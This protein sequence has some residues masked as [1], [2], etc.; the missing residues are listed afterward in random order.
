MRA[1]FVRRADSV[2]SA[3]IAPDA[4]QTGSAG[5]MPLDE[6]LRGLF[7]DMLPRGFG[8]LPNGVFGP[9]TRSAGTSAI[10]QQSGGDNMAVSEA[11]AFENALA[12]IRERYAL[13][14]YLPEGAKPGDERAVETDLSD[15]ARQRY[16]G[17][18]V[19]YRSPNGSKNSEDTGPMW[20]SLPRIDS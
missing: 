19:R 6:R 7:G 9:R 13:Y 18:K 5:R 17:A 20:V 14:F 4:L 10:A 8:S 2:L 12:R 15:A 1:C 11:D 16:P 3:L